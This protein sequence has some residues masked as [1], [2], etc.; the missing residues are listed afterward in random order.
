YISTTD[1]PFINLAIEEWLLRHSDPDRMTLYLWR[2]RPCVVIGRN[3]N[4]WKE[5]DQVTMKQKDIWL[6]RRQSGGGTV[7]HD[8]GNSLYTVIMPRSKFT[9]KASAQLVARALH[10]LDIPAGVNERHDI[11]IGNRKISGSA[12]KIIGKSAYH[13]GTMLINSNLTSLSDCLKNSRVSIVSKGVES[14]RSPVTKLA[15]YSLTVNHKAFCDAVQSE[16]EQS[17]CDAG[18]N[19]TPIYID[20]RMADGIQHIAEYETKLKVSRPTT[21][22]WVYG[23][24]PEFENTIDCQPIGLSAVSSC[25]TRL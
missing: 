18:N 17:Y 14:V 20:K 12:Y 2:N 22:D 9:R 23:Q 10:M 24:T 3:Q 6:V 15:D 7:Y 8:L 1:D 19:L 4:P 21:W 11:T 5:C 25:S 16:F 13:H